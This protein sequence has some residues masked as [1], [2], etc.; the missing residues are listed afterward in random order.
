MKKG[1]MTVVGTGL[2][3][4]LCVGM[5]QEASADTDW[6]F[7]LSLGFS[8]GWPLFTPVAPPV[9]ATPPVIVTRPVVPAPVVVAPK[10]V[11]VGPRPFSYF[12]G[13]KQG[14]KQGFRQGFRQGVR[15]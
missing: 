9:V 7:S 12:S 10:P 15:Y 3:V 1:L 4:V 13:Y 14:Y 8:S 11:V 2:V 5:V 6:A